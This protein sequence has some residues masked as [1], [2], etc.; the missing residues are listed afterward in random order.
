MR[1]LPFLIICCCFHYATFTFAAAAQ[2][3]DTSDFTT[4]I[5]VRHAEKAEDGTRDPDLDVYGKARANRLAQLLHAANISAIYSTPFKRTRQTANPLAEIL[6]LEVLDYAPLDLDAFSQL[7]ATKKGQTI[8]LIGHSNTVPAMVN[9]LLG[10][11]A[12]GQLGETEY[13]KIFMVQLMG[14]SRQLTTLS[15]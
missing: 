7:V 1:K 8:V 2:P 15:Y 3:I 5:L 10:K 4:V 6:Q 14:E 12:I 13:D 9:H 11:E